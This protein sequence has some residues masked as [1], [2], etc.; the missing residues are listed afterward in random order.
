MSNINWKAVKE[1]FDRETETLEGGGVIVSRDGSVKPAESHYG[2]LFDT[3]YEE[4]DLWFYNGHPLSA[5]EFEENGFRYRIQHP[6][7]VADEG[8]LKYW[9]EDSLEEFPAV[10]LGAMSV[11]ATDDELHGWFFI[12]KGEAV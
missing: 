2:E 12:I 4:D 7:A 9:A 5:D 10:F 6:S 11:P 3:V 8:F 1:L